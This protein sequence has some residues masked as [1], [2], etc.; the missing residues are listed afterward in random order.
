MRK[1]L[2][3]SI[4]HYVLNEVCVYFQVVLRATL[5]L[6]LVCKSMVVEYFF[7]KKVEYLKRFSYICT[8]FEN[9]EKLESI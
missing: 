9:L 3:V 7:Y 4:F 6:V 2:I 5:V 8:L 1:R